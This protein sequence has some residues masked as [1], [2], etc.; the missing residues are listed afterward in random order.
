MIHLLY[1]SQF[2]STISYL[3]QNISFIINEHFAFP[4]FAASPSSIAIFTQ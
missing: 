2:P 1:R 3:G 4:A